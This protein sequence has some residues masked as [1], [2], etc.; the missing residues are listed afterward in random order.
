M[1]F[2]I[3]TCGFVSNF[4][5]TIIQHLNH[6]KPRTQTF[7]RRMQDMSEK[8]IMQTCLTTL[9]WITLSRQSGK[10]RI[11]GTLGL[12][13]A[14]PSLTL[15]PGPPLLQNTAILW[16]SRC[17]SYTSDTLDVS[18]MLIVEATVGGIPPPPS[19]IP[20]HQVTMEMCD[21]SIGINSTQ[22]M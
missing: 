13:K 11:K 15:L 7:Y 3:N 16:P 9:F 12:I 6:Q 5:K 2:I 4:N 14:H 8:Q 17:F 20:H 10:T 21:V 22:T 19:L 18:L 1:F